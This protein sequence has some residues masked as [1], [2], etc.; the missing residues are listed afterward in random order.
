VSG[1]FVIY[2]GRVADNSSSLSRLATNH[3]YVHL[4]SPLLL[5]SSERIKQVV[6]RELAIT[7]PW[8]GKI[9]IIL[10]PASSP[11]DLITIVSER[12]R[13]GWQYRVAMPDLLERAKYVR[14]MVQVLLLEYANRTA[15]ERSAEIPPW[16]IEG[17]A[18]EALL[19]S[20]QP[21]IPP[22]VSGSGG[23]A[24]SESFREARL[25]N[26]LQE[27]HRV[28]R[29]SDPLTFEELSWPRPEH[30]EGERTGVYHACAQVFVSRLQQMPG[31]R[32]CL[33]S[34]VEQLPRHHNWQFAFLSAFRDRFQRP[35]EVEKWWTLQLVHF[36]GRDL[37]NMLSGA[38][39]WAKLDELLRQPVLVR[40]QTNDLPLRSDVP[41][42]TVL[43]QWDLGAQY[44]ALQVKV[45]ELEGFQVRSAPE[46]AALAEEYR[47][48]LASYLPEPNKLNGANTR[49]PPKPRRDAGQTVLAL[50]VL[51]QRRANFSNAASGL[52]Q[53]PVEGRL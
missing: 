14:A 28:L 33:R 1:Q 23:L 3:N 49:K 4:R 30:I 53:A 13:D 10:Y 29:V 43:R 39:S 24:M 47:Q 17:L 12:F 2:S 8:A 52:K 9:H 18:Q 35:L 26:P 25:E 38:E 31:G 21:V 27:A 46:A 22:A 6:G 51:D 45:R 48:L 32:A 15:G 16:L 44:Q 34:M 19:G 36:T 37:A 20:E 11:A 5:V 50:S 40:S 42:Q 7:A 41:L